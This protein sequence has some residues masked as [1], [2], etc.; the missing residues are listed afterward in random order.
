MSIDLRADT[1]VVIGIAIGDRT[2]LRILDAVDGQRTLR[3]VARHVGVCP[4]TAHH[5]LRRLREAGLVG[6]ERRGVH[7]R[8]VRRSGRWDALFSIPGA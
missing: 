4:S 2:R 1:I 6:V 5:H 7:H 3:E 8:L